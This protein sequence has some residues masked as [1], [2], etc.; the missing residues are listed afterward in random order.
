LTKLD[1]PLTVAL[2]SDVI[3]RG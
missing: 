2:L 1:N 3:V